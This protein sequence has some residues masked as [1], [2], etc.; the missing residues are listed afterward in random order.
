MALAMPPQYQYQVYFSFLAYFSVL[1][2]AADGSK[3]AWVWS[4]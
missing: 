1:S 4:E 2:A 3:W